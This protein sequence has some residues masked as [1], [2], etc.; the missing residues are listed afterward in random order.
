MPIRIARALLVV[1]VLLGLGSF[2]FA[3]AVGPSMAKKPVKR[4][5]RVAPVKK[6]TVKIEVKPSAVSVPP[7]NTSTTTTDQ[8]TMPVVKP[9][10]IISPNGGGSYVAGTMLRIEWSGGVPTQMVDVMLV[11]MS[12]VSGGLPN[13][14]ALRATNTGLFTWF[15]PATQASGQYMVRVCE[16][17][18][19][20]SGA[21]DLSDTPFTIFVSYDSSS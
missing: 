20:A 21:S 5:V 15:I 12:G 2:G 13:I 16:Q 7:K 9:L 10:R 3:L 11:P 1:A 4:T 6:P 17:A 14:I 19:C 8:T 18:A